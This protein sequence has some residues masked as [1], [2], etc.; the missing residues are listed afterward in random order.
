[1]KSQDKFFYGLLA[2]A[3]LAYAKKM[4]YYGNAE[5]SPYNRY[6]HVYHEAESYHQ[7]EQMPRIPLKRIQRA[8]ERETGM[9]F[10]HPPNLTVIESAQYVPREN[11]VIVDYQ[12]NNNRMK[13]YNAVIHEYLHAV[14]SQ[15]GRPSPHSKLFP[16]QHRLYGKLVL[17]M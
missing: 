8:I 6:D 14:Y 11:K 7:S 13:F 10:K 12:M 5:T 17:G 1:M 3:G 4:A 16:L 2:L 9:K 15:N